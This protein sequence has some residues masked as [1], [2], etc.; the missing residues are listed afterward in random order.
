MTN[1]E[2]DGVS[3][4]HGRRIVLGEE[5]Q[6]PARKSKEL[7]RRRKKEDCPHMDNITF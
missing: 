4:W 1:R 6:R 5:K 3:V 7:D 2:V